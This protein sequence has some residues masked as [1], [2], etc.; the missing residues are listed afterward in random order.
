MKFANKLVPTKLAIGSEI[1]IGKNITIEAL[2]ASDVQTL[3]S[4]NRDSLSIWTLFGAKPVA[5]LT[6]LL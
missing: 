3:V 1:G 2:V 6:E 4:G 5:A